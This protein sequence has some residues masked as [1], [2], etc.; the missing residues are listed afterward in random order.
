MSAPLFCC[1]ISKWIADMCYLLFQKHSEDEKI[2][3]EAEK[4]LFQDWK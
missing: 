1:L 2:Q 4:D 3:D